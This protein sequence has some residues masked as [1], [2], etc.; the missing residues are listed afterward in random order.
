[1]DDSISS[2]QSRLCAA[3]NFDTMMNTTQMGHCANMANRMRHVLL[4]V[5][6]MMMA[7]QP[8]N[9]MD[10]QFKKCPSCGCIWAKFVGCNG[11][12]TCGAAHGVTEVDGGDRNSRASFSF[13]FENGKLKI[14]KNAQSVK[15]EHRGG[16]KEDKKFGAGCGARISWSEMASVGLEEMLPGLGITMS[17]FLT[18]C[19]EE[20][21]PTVEDVA[22][23]QAEQAQQWGDYMSDKFKKLEPMRVKDMAAPHRSWAS[24]APMRR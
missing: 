23:I 11:S 10:N 1:M 8:K 16:R 7:Y 15:I 3:C 2:A 17:Q 12:T 5:R 9:S 18:E 13:S 20:H 21:N 14:T 19:T 24:M 4:E 6:I 22:V